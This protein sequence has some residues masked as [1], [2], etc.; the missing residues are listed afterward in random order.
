MKPAYG[1]EIGMLV[2]SKHREGKEGGSVCVCVLACVCVYQF[3]EAIS[4][5]RIHVPTAESLIDRIGPVL[6]IGGDQKYVREEWRYL[7]QLYE[8]RECRLVENL[9]ESARTALIMFR[10]LRKRHPRYEMKR[11][12]VCAF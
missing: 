3:Q 9:G 4:E 12:H 11:F 7:R 2:A 1:N 5:S 6:V 10:T 8:G